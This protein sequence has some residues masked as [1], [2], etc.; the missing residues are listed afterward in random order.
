MIIFPATGVFMDLGA[1]GVSMF[2]VSYVTLSI[3][4]YSICSLGHTV[5]LS[6]NSSIR[7][8]HL[9]LQVQMAA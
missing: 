1:M 9:V 5:P 4:I 7:Q 2:F 8:V 6:L 3:H